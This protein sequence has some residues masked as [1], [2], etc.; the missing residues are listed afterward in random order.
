[1]VALALGVLIGTGIVMGLALDWVKH[2]DLIPVR[3]S[4]PGG[5]RSGAQRESTYRPRQR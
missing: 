5:E 3:I 2:P 4:S 1:M